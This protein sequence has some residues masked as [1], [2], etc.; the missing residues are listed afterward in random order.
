MNHLQSQAAG[1]L[2]A[3]RRAALRGVAR[4]DQ[5]AQNPTAEATILSAQ[6]AGHAAREAGISFLTAGKQIAE[7]FRAAAAAKQAAA[8]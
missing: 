3:I 1:P 8:E 6:T 5:A 4:L 2:G 7:Q